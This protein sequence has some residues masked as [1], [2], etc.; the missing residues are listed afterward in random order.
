MEKGL[1]PGCFFFSPVVNIFPPT[2]TYRVERSA[3]TG[4]RALMVVVCGLALAG[5]EPPE[6]GETTDEESGCA[7]KCDDGNASPRVLVTGFYDWGNGAAP[8][9]CNVNPT[10][11]LTE[12]ALLRE[13][14]AQSSAL[15]ETD[16]LEV[17][18]GVFTDT[19]GDNAGRY[20]FVVNLGL[21]ETLSYG[22]AEI[23]HGAYNLKYGP[24]VRGTMK[25][26]ACAWQQE[27]EIIDDVPEAITRMNEVAGN[28]YG[29]VS[30]GIAN[31]RS[32]N[33]FICN[34]THADA[35]IASRTGGFVPFFIH[36]SSD[37]ASH[38]KDIAAVIA[39]LV[40]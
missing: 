20:D 6:G 12:G 23:E 32:G 22:T 37:M 4:I 27:Y 31:A 39:D 28:R 9:D 36:V 33:S 26:E 30:V 14:Q 24:D 18:W 3:M 16:T 19:Y 29:A 1:G 8:T 10:C 17:R 7:G 40:D 13:L 5:C 11:M 34:E 2:C 25:H 21:N 38:P 15:W 35:I